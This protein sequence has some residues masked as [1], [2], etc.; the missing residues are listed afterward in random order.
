MLVD[1]RTDLGLRCAESSALIFT[2]CLLPHLNL[3]SST[4][5]LLCYGFSYRNC[6]ASN[7]MLMIAWENTSLACPSC[8]QCRVDISRADDFLG[9]WHLHWCLILWFCCCC[10]LPWLR[11]VWSHYCTVEHTATGGGRSAP[12]ARLQWRNNYKRHKLFACT[13]LRSPSLAV[14]SFNI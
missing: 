13:E 2:S 10:L 3:T 8:R 12:T 1:R 14:G 4:L 5:L 9:T 7:D 11:I 6:I